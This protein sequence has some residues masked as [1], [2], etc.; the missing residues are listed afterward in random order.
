V[1]EGE[2]EDARTAVEVYLREK[3]VEAEY[4]A[5][6]P[7]ATAAEYSRELKTHPEQQAK[8]MLVRCA[9]G[10][11]KSYAAVV[12][13]AQK[14]VDL[15]QIKQ[16]LGAHK[17]NLAD[18]ARLVEITGCDFGEVHPFASLYGVPL[19]MDRDFLRQERIYINAGCL[20][21]S[22]VMRP[23]ELVRLERPVMF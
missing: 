2:M 23:E 4:V 21:R 10:G 18:R 8:V 13:Q 15:E 19:M 12:I 3:G 1:R 11:Q 20:N 6:A 17:V 9:H 7:A 16:T 14:R 22:V 5:H